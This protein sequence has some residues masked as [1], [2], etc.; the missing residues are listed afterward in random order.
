MAISN[1]RLARLPI[2]MSTAIAATYQAKHAKRIKSRRCLRK[3]N[4]L[5]RRIVDG[6]VV[7]QNTP[8]SLRK[9][10]IRSK[11]KADACFILGMGG[12]RPFLLAI[13]SNRI[14]SH[15]TETSRICGIR[16]LDFS[17]REPRLR[18]ATV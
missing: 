1:G 7:F 6:L 8:L 15:L 9:D 2:L 17:G 18:L 5:F 11:E 14:D 13:E 12:R 10:A 4:L 3:E 16:N